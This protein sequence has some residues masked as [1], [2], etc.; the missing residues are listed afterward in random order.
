MSDLLIER[1]VID[2]LR[3]GSFQEFVDLVEARIQKELGEDAVVF[4]THRDHAFAIANDRVVKV[5][6]N[7]DNDSEDVVVEDANVDVVTGATMDRFVRRKLRS[8]AEMAIEEGS[9]DELRNRLRDLAPYVNKKSIYWFDDIEKLVTGLEESSSW[10]A[11]FRENETRIK[12]A[13][14]GHLGKIDELIP[15]NHFG[16]ASSEKLKTLRES[17]FESIEVLSKLFSG[18]SE[19][20]SGLSFS[21][22]KSRGIDLDASAVQKELLGEC[23]TFQRALSAAIKIAESEDLV[24]LARIHDSVLNQIRQVLITAKFLEFGGKNNV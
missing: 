1:E 6:W 11:F 15:R 12:K 19:D 18:L 13:V 4:A 21:E 9:D 8:I 7:M 5:S 23:D 22:E 10:R 3:S 24:K 14:R 20:L 2:G 17:L 16:W